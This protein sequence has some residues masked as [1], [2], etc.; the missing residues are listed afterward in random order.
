MN[1]LAPILLS[2]T[3]CI[4]LAC[5][6]D[7]KPIDFTA[8]EWRQNFAS[9]DSDDFID[10]R[11]DKTY[12]WVKIGEQVWMAEN[13]N[14]EARGWCNGN[15]EIYG[16]LYDWTEAMTACPSGWRLPSD[17][18]WDALITIAGGYLEAGW[19]L[20]AKSGWEQNGN[21]IDELGFTALPGGFSGLNAG[22]SSYWWS[23]SADDDY[24]A[25]CRAMYFDGSDV[26]KFAMSK[27]QSL[28]VR[29]IKN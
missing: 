9:S 7:F 21:G 23:A 1:K 29:C 18:E 27:S 2:I 12:K 19:V 26:E 16:R 14:Y 15:C 17:A 22:N 25:Y 11:D 6:G 4:F 20:K 5:S 28:S 24:K 8:E 3:A 13:L 10:D